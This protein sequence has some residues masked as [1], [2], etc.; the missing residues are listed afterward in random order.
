MHTNGCH[1]CREHSVF[2][3]LLAAF[4]WKGAECHLVTCVLWLSG[5][6][7]GSVQPESQ[8]AQLLGQRPGALPLFTVSP[9]YGSL[10]YP[11]P[12]AALRCFWHSCKPPPSGGGWGEHRLS[13]C[14]WSPSSC[15][16]VTWP[17]PC[18]TMAVLIPG[19][20]PGRNPE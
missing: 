18:Y 2:A 14:F 1:A 5:P 13:R 4:F 9:G 6:V 12:V 10:S 7:Q 17:D 8:T 16:P 15:S 19:Q 20:P 3:P 11:A